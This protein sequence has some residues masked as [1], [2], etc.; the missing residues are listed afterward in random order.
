MADLIALVFNG[1]AIVAALLLLVVYTLGLVV[2]RLHLSPLAKFPGPK[3]AAGEFW[4]IPETIGQNG[5]PLISYCLVRI[6]VRLHQTWQIYIR[7]QEDARE[8]RF[9]HHRSCLTGGH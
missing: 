8:I 1:R 9:A 2:Y 7:D 6:L 4:T 3:L 5:L